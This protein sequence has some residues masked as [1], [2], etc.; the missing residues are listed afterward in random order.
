MFGKIISRSLTT[1]GPIERSILAGVTGRS[2]LRVDDYSPKEMNAILALSRH[3]KALHKGNNLIHPQD[4]TPL[5]GKSLAMIF[6]KMSSS[7]L[8]NPCAILLLF[9][10]VTT[11]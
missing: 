5:T 8:T 10:P 7:V 2:L 4:N 11:R 1:Y 9:C 6:Q 3:I